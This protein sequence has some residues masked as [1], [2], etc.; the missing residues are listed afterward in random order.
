MR[1]IPSR[2]Y[3]LKDYKCDATLLALQSEGYVE[4]LVTLTTGEELK[5]WVQAN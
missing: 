4:K 5:A 3:R 1:I 2:A